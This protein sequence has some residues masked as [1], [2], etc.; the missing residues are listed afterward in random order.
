MKS[1]IKI[2]AVIMI[3]VSFIVS[4]CQSNEEKY[5]QLKTETVKLAEATW[6]ESLSDAG[7]K[8]SNEDIVREYGKGLKIL[9]EKMPT[10]EK[11]AK[12]MEEL[13]KSEIKLANDYHEFEKTY[14]VRLRERQKKY[15]G[16]VDKYS[17]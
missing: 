3:M 11:N 4:G 1:I 16:Y 2:F 9:N 8:P 6:K 7:Y 13:A 15:K 5:T 12:A 10:I 17:K 14:I